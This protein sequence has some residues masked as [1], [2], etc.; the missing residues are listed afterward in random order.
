MSD[1]VLDGIAGDIE[2]DEHAQTLGTA[3]GFKRAE[4]RRYIATNW[5]S[6][7]KTYAGT[8]AMLYDWRQKT[9]PGEQ[10]I[11]LQTALKESG[12]IMLAERYLKTGEVKNNHGHFGGGGGGEQQPIK[13]TVLQLNRIKETKRKLRNVAHLLYRIIMGFFYFTHYPLLSL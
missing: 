4:S 3:L 10:F 6:G 1:E 5:M 11:K 8:R 13:V 2:S 7:C 9:T 12:M